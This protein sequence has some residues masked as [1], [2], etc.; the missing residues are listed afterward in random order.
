MTT[1]VL[2]KPQTVAADT[3]DNIVHRELGCYPNEALCGVD[4]TGHAAVNSPTNCVVC[5]D[6]EASGL[7]CD[8]IRATRQ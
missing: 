3:A 4:L 8:E 6:L 2:E 5:R 7:N 1:E